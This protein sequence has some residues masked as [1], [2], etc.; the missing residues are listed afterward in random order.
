MGQFFKKKKDMLSKEEVRASFNEID[1]DKSGSIELTELTNLCAKLNLADVD[2]GS[3]QDLFKEIDTNHDGKI[4][5][6]EFLA[7]YRLGRNSKLRDVLKFQ[8]SAMSTFDTY[9]TKKYKPQSEFSPEGRETLVDI[10]LRE[11]EPEEGKTKFILKVT[12]KANE[13]DWARVTKACPN[14]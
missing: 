7:W 2:H 5:F 8:L 13:D 10:D 4:S 11:G 6:D 1:T 14:L 9:F 12:P 3:V